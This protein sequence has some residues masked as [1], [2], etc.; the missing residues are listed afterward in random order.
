[1]L[2]GRRFGASGPLRRVPTNSPWQGLNFRLR[3]QNTMS[4][5]PKRKRDVLA[6]GDQGMTG[7]QDRIVGRAR[8]ATHRKGPLKL[9]TYEAQ[10][11]RGLR[12]HASEERRSWQPITM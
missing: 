4:M 9:V 8:L 1:M 2:I 6:K 12:L 10:R 3:S 11:A 7:A 5:I